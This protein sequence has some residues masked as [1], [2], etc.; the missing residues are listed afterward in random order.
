MSNHNLDTKHK[1]E[2]LKKLLIDKI[3][4]DF[5]P[6]DK[7]YTQRKIMQE[8][9]MGYSTVEKALN[10][11]VESGV[12]TRKQ[13]SGTF[14]SSG[15][16]P[17]VKTIAVIVYHMDNPFYSKII[18]AAEQTARKN[19]YHLITCNTLGNEET[20][21]NYV[22]ELIKEKK[23]SGFLICPT[24]KRLNSEIFTLIKNRKIP[25]VLFPVVD[26]Q[27]ALLFDYVITNET[28]GAYLATKHLLEQGCRNIAFVSNKTEKDISTANRLAGY[29]NALQEAGVPFDK[30]LWIKC[31]SLEEKGGEEA[32]GYILERKISP[33]GIFAMTDLIAIGIIRK[34]RACGLKVGENV[35]IV[36]FDDIDMASWPEFSL[37]T[38]NQPRM[39]IGNIAAQILI[40]RCNG[41]LPASGK[42]TLEPELIIRKTSMP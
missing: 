20:E 7:F 27:A 14:V 6:G 3:D 2:Q 19:G 1:Y 10:L 4:T 30:T 33:D 16:S 25:C 38:I 5:K 40:D 8:Y 15:F 24:D 29:L 42:I 39:E 21:I 17:K 26:T 12:L 32:A 35:R 9:K 41:T 28:K 18:K 37:S 31:G 11:L 34:L 23:V 36:G 13:G 22:N